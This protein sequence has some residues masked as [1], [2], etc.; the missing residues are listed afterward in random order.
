MGYGSFSLNPNEWLK[1]WPHGSTAASSTADNSG[2]LVVNMLDY[3]RLNSDERLTDVTL[4]GR[5]LQLPSGERIIGKTAIHLLPMWTANNGTATIQRWRGYSGH[6]HSPPVDGV[7]APTVS[8]D[9][10][11]GLWENADRTPGLGV[12]AAAAS[13]AIALAGTPEEVRMRIA[14]GSFC[15]PLFNYA[16]ADTVY[17]VGR[18]YVC[19]LVDASW[20]AVTVQAIANGNL[21]IF[22]HV[23]VQP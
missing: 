11:V 19:E 4:G 3:L 8:G 1:I 14:P 7:T 10:G 5:M 21:V 16:T 13:L 20:F 2:N 6:I 15:K 12:S 17:F 23:D 22:A 18:R 9:R